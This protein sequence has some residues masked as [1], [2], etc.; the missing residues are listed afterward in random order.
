MED[1][2]TSPPAEPK[3]QI[4]RGIP[5]DFPSLEDWII[6]RLSESALAQAADSKDFVREFV[7]YIKAGRAAPGRN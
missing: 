3:H 4:E 6:K 2:C 5:A 1:V 7:E